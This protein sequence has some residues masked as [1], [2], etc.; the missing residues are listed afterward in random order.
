MATKAR[1]PI[2]REPGEAVVIEDFI[3]DDLAPED[4]LVRIFA[5]GVCHTDLPK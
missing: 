2:A 3:I 4:V 1:D 5:S